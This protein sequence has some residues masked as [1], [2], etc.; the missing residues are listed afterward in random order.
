MIQTFA[1]T[2]TRLA[3]G[4]ELIYFD[5]QAQAREIVDARAM[6]LARER[7]ELR[8]DAMRDEWVAVASHRHRRTHLP[9]PEACPLC[10]STALRA[11]EIPARDYDVVVFEN[12]FPAFAGPPVDDA[13]APGVGA[14][15]VG[16]GRCEVMCFT[17]DHDASFATLTPRRLRTVV[18]AWVDRTLTLGAMDGVE[19]VF[20]FENCGTEIGVTLTHPHGQIYGYPFVTP[21]TAQELRALAA[22][23]AVTGRDLTADVLAA[24]RA[25]GSRIVRSTTHWTAFVPFA[26]RW[27][28]EIHVLPNRRAIDLP[29]LSD[30][31]R[32]D[33]CAVYP[34]V[35]RRVE[36][37]AGPDAPYIASWHQA[38]TRVGRDLATLRLEV[39]SVRRGDDKIKYLAGSESAM[40]V[41]VN[42]VRPED[43]ARAL[44]DATP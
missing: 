35:L 11:T 24:E 13:L 15:S 43:V 34:D 8:Y 39:F 38:P 5:E 20:V 44:R 41:F 23:R 3:D 30:A 27:P 31:E 33:L 7:S 19:Q 25:D 22:H 29:D 28:L 2:S 21:R 14:T 6:P 4:R 12:R 10:P 40:G 42:D 26:A 36:Q 37:V 32:D 18:E 1:R 17:S 9:A 16:R